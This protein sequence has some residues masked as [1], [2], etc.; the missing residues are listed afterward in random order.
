MRTAFIETLCELAAGNDRIWLLCG[1]LGYSVLERFAERF[2]DRY[3]N[4]G[5]AE[6]NMTGVAAGLTLSG[7]TVFTYSIANF[8]TLR[9]LEQIRNDVCY[10]GGDVKIVA[11]GGGLSYGSLGY[12][13]HG[14]EDLAIMRA[15]P[16]MSVVAP[17]DPLEVRAVTRLITE[18]KGPCYLRLSRGGD[19][20][21]HSAPPSLE[22]GKAI[23]LR[24]GRH[25]VVLATGG[26]LKTAMDAALMAEQEGCDV[27]V[28]SCP[29]VSPLDSS[30]IMELATR[31]S[32]L[33]TVEEARDTGGFGGSVAELIAGSKG[34]CRVLRVGIPDRVLTL[35]CNQDE[36][37]NA[38]GLDAVTITRKLVDAVKG[39]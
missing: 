12:T 21:V 36:A 4:V 38:Y 16:G 13:H 2:P 33:V 32:T 31:Y 35:A 34:R 37:R 5:V 14:I 30:L 8:P 7:K 28:W 23:R 20:V 11:V 24:E 18:R 10:H 3:V 6:Q 17:A 15:L 27:A 26:M 39:L 19:P 1:D 25:I 9:C 22:W 29:W